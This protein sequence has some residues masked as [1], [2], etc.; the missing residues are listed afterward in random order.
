MLKLKNYFDIKWL[1]LAVT[2]TVTVL[3][4]THIPQKFMPSQMQE[5]GVDKLLHVL[6]YGAITLLLIFSVKSPPSI[7]LALKIL[8]VL[9][10]IG[11]FDEITQ[12][13][14]GRQSSLTDFMTDVTGVI[15]VLLVFILYKQQFQKLKIES[16]SL[17]CF[18]A[19]VAFAAGILIVPATLFSMNK[20]GGSSLK[21]QQKEARHFFY[22]TMYKLFEGKYNPEEGIVSKD[23]LQI[24]NE[25][26]HQLGNKCKLFIYDDWFSRNR[27]KAGFFIGLVFFPSE[28]MYSVEIERKDG[29]FILKKLSLADWEQDW[30]EE[31]HKSK[32]H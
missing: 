14:V 9:S 32:K 25:H 24:F 19:V 21:E 1:V 11:I 26:R 29:S 23:A 20:I 22:R 2:F 27:Q 7:N 28:D 18:T 17:L 4:L 15:V 30:K 5:R 10:A 31:L 13:L 6:A 8:F 3:I 12:P 16:A